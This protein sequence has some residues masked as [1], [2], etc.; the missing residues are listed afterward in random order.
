MNVWHNL[1]SIDITVSKLLTNILRQA[2]DDTD[3]GY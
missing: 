3:S 1:N 2:Q